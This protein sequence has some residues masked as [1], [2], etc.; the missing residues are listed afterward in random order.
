MFPR[1]A[2]I[3]TI[4]AWLKQAAIAVFFL[5]SAPVI[6]DESIVIAGTFRPQFQIV[7]K[8][9]RYSVVILQIEF[10]ILIMIATKTMFPRLPEEPWYL[11][12][13][14]SR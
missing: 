10:Y 14:V 8:I 11:Y 2:Y 7:N 5:F 1:F 13:P 3:S 12:R 4:T 6:F 9:F